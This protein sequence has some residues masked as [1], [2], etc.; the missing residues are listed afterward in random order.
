MHSQIQL[1]FQEKQQGEEV[2][3]IIGCLGPSMHFNFLLNEMG[4]RLLL[5]RD[6]YIIMSNSISV[7]FFLHV[8]Q[9]S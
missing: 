7:S 1:G 6:V 9:N 2:K 3:Y 4:I 8:K 5:Y